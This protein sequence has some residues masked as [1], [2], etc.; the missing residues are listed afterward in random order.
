MSD[1]RPPRFF[2]FDLGN[3]LL[4][5][6]HARAARQ[7]AEVA[8]VSSE[9]IWD[10]VYASGL[11]LRRETRELSD[12][13]YY[14]AICERIGCR[15]DADRLELA[16]CDIFR[17][18]LTMIPVIA[19]LKAAGYR[20]GMLSN[21]CSTH[22]DFFA[23]GRFRLIPEAFDVVIASFEI[24]VMKPDPLI[25]RIAAE[26]AG[27][28]PAELFFVDDIPANVAGA[29]DAGVDAVLY[30]GTPQLIRELRARGVRFND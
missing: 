16:G 19:Q 1:V 28:S 20:L 12:D 5:F 17:S 13:A 25:Y 18:N 29:R 30:T 3:V 26:R 8:G 15:P 4:F 10:V 11:F 24:G 27:V 23:S 21:T 14:E 2:Y 9:L 6:D 22:Y 7:M